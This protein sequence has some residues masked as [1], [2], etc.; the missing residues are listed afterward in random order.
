MFTIGGLLSFDYP[1]FKTRNLRKVVLEVLPFCFLFILYII[2]L[3]WTQDLNRGLRYVEHALS[4]LIFPFVIFV[5][6]PFQTQKQVFYF[7]RIFIVSAILF[8]LLIVINIYFN[9]GLQNYPLRERIAEV[10]LIGEHP[11][12]FSLLLA[13]GIILILFYPFERKWISSIFIMALSVGVFIAA[14]RGVFFALL[15]SVIVA[16]FLLIKNR[17]RI[18][19]VL[20]GLVFSS[21]VAII[22]S[23]L[24]ER[25]QEFTDTVYMY[26]QG[27]HYNSFNLRMAIYKCSLTIIKEKPLI[28]YGPGDIQNEL[29]NCYEMFPTKAFGYRDYNTH[30]QYL[31]YLCAFGILG[32]IIVLGFFFFYVKLCFKYR[33]WG[34]FIFLLLFYLSFFTENI[35]GRNTGIVVFAMFNCILAYNSHYLSNKGAI[36]S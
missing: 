23:P 11:I 3:I 1:Q 9:V 19:F 14:T 6:K 32:T 28:G 13:T 2:S 35:L 36:K 25:M 5:L 27:I 15:I 16:L 22:A 10:P 20:L 17:K 12:Y 29:N 33:D 24:K 31:H 34:Y 7:I 18:A 4:F 8:C 21:I 30:N 26:P